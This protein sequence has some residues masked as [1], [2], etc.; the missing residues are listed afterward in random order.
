MSQE[1]EALVGKYPINEADIDVTEAA[2]ADWCNSALRHEFGH[3]TCLERIKRW[4]ALESDPLLKIHLKEGM[5]PTPM[6]Y[7]IPVHM[8]SQ[9]KG[10]LQL[11]RNRVRNKYVRRTAVLLVYL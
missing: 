11:Y 8:L 10:I 6:K 2:F 3:F 1:H 5:H 7:R 9:L 4:E